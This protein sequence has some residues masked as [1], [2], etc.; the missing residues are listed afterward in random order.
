MRNR[1][2]KKLIRESLATGENTIQNN[3]LET[4][5]NELLVSHLNNVRQRKINRKKRSKYALL[6]ASLL[7]VMFATL[8]VITSIDEIKAGNFNIIDAIKNMSENTE[9]DQISKRDA[10]PSLTE[11]TI[12]TYGSYKEMFEK[13]EIIAYFKTDFAEPD[14]KIKSLEVTREGKGNTI[15]VY[16]YRKE[17]ID[18]YSI[19]GYF[20]NHSMQ[21]SEH[22]THPGLKFHSV[23]V[24]GI[25]VDLY[26]SQ[27]LNFAHFKKNDIAFIVEYHKLSDDFIENLVRNIK[28]YGKK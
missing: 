10:F 24:D 21:Q 3:E 2:I 20:E 16:Y 1:R 19:Q 7:I 18:M 28:V 6:T 26:T 13:N 8:L 9:V 23:I 12:T 27:E 22:L 25:V 14:F 5:W 17:P 4:D 15:L 11:K